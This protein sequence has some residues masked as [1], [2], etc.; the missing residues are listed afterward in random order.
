MKMKVENKTIDKLIRGDLSKDE[1]QELV[2]LDYVLTWKYSINQEQDLKRYKELS[3]IKWQ[4]AYN[5]KYKDA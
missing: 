4:T 5:G 2:A 3:N 1:W